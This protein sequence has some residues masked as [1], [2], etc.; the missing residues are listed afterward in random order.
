M[1]TNFKSGVVDIRITRFA[2]KGGANLIVSRPCEQEKF[3]GGDVWDRL[4][5]DRLIVTLA[6]AHQL[7]QTLMALSSEATADNIELDHE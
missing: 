3:D 4:R 7:A 1:S 2:G 6:E 5:R